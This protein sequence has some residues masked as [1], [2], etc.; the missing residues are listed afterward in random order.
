MEN[1]EEKEEGLP[2]EAK[3][4]I[5]KG[6][7]HVE[8]P[9]FMPNGEYIAYGMLHKAG[10]MVSVFFSHIEKETRKNPEPTRILRPAG[11]PGSH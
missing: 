4:F 1:G 6:V 9:L 5:D 2:K 8:V 10:Q 3:G 7:L 11:L